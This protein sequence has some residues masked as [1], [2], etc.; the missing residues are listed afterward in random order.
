MH[1]LGFAALYVSVVSFIALLFSYIDFLVPDQLSYYLTSILNQ[2]RWSSATLLVMF[3]VYIWITWT[4]EKEIKTNP[5]KKE[6]RSRKWL[7]YFT[8]FVAAITVI[9]DLI[10]LVYNFYSGELTTKFFWKILVVLVVAGG[11]F[12]YY[13]WVLNRAKG[14]SS[15][16]KLLTWIV[17][18]V[19]AAALVGGF[20]I[21]GSPATQR[22]RRFD[23]QRINDLQSIQYQVLNY[24]QKKGVIPDSLDQLK[25][26]F[27][28][29]MPPHD[30]ETNKSYEYELV[31]QSALRFK[32]CA[33]FK[34]NGVSYGSGNAYPLAVRDAS[35]PHGGQTDNWTHDAGRVCFERSI[36]KDI[37]G[38]PEQKGTTIPAY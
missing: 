14:A 25:D 28:G 23:D 24:W 11:V 10:T 8:L 29:Y 12:G 21:V 2:I 13:R 33:D 6:L 34:T 7:I 22:A 30:P 26:E 19:V 15:K 20:F 1:L 17:S 35:Y 16:S 3:P 5:E 37:Y 36:D 32:L 9:I 31:G 38:L 27:S 4:L 18:I